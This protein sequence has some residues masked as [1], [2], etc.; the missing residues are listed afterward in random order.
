M[1]V[2]HAGEVDD[3]LVLWGELSE[4]GGTPGRRRGR[5]RTAKKKRSP[6]RDNTSGGKHPFSAGAQEIRRLL[7]SQGG[8][9]VGKDYMTTSI[10]LPSGGGRPVPSSGIGSKSTGSARGTTL[11][12]WSVEIL[13]LSRDEAMRVLSAVAR[14][15]TLLAGMVVGPDLAYWSDVLRLAS[16]MV[17]R[18]QILPGLLNEYVY[19][20]VW[21]PVL[22]GKDHERFT[23]LARHM[24][25][26][27]QAFAAGNE[28]RPKRSPAEIL[29]RVLG[30]LVDH[31]VRS[32]A[33][34]NL[35][36]GYGRR[37]HFDS[38]HDSWFHAL[39]GGSGML[40][41]TDGAAE[42]ETGINEWQQTITTLDDSPF[43]L[44]F[45]LEEPPGS[46]AK[47]RGRAWF[48]RYLLQSRNDPSLV[49]PADRVWG[50]KG[51]G[52][53]S[54]L[55]REGPRAKEFLLTSL[56]R[57][58]G[59]IAEMSPGFE[60]HGME[61]Y[62]VDV[63]GAYRFL[64]EEAP[65]LEQ[66]GYGIMLPAWWV[67]KGTKT[68]LAAQAVVTPKMRAKGVLNLDSVVRFDWRLALGD[69]RIT[70][71][72]L[73]SLAKIKSPLVSIRGQW[74]ET[75]SGEIRRAIRFL[76]KNRGATLRDTVMMEFGSNAAAPGWMDLRIVSRDKQ[77]TRMM[78]RL[79]RNAAMK[80]LPQPRGFTGTLRP[81][82][83]HGY[84][85]LSFLQ[86]LGIGGCLADDMGLGKTVQVLALV[87]RYVRAAGKGPIL[88]VCPTS[89]MDNWSR[90]AARFAPELSVTIHH[91]S[92]RSGGRTFAREAAG[93]DMVVSSYALLHRDI[94]FVRRVRWGG[95]I[96]DEAQNVKNAETKQS[97]AVRALDAGFRFALTG[98][99][100]ENSVADIW[101]I[102]EFLNP[103]LLGTQAEFKRNFF[104][105]I[106]TN[107]DG[108]AIDTLKRT[109]GP[110]ML[111]RLKT[112]R[113]V[114][115]DL[116]KK[117]EMN[118][119][120]SLTREQASL[121]A[122]VLKELDDRLH[123][124]DGIQRKG[125]IL[126][127]LSKLKQ[128]CNHPAHL[129][130]DG[131]AIPDRSG[132][133]A[134]LTEMLEEV[135]NSG[136]RALVFTQFVEMGEILVRHIHETFGREVAFLHGGVPKRQRDRMVERFQDGGF[137]VFVVSL[138]AGG[139]GLNLMAANHVF[140][141]DRWWNPAVENQ[142][143]DRAYRIGQ[144]RNVQVYKMV[145]TGTMEERIDEIIEG[146][147]EISENV[148]G[149]GEGWLT[150]L[151][152][153][154]IRQVLALSRE[155][156]TRI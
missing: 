145:C 32:A 129:L 29:R 135:I 4:S 105:P 139:T 67:G 108:G 2:L 91:G 27:G 155:E 126:A 55:R 114:I 30:R 75:G 122:S 54:A 79:R 69:K 152:N 36:P 76:A 53:P 84:S 22:V 95:V 12:Q 23:A 96:L 142:A 8:I 107:R 89:V 59:I 1:I 138:R 21:R 60:R 58:S 106:Q 117:M 43:R 71:K 82:Q 62:A 98:T 81:Y 44:C 101:S 123:S 3:S 41:D 141:F 113:T 134:R 78:N 140:H 42:L 136:E 47:A 70:L 149:T 11:V 83:L 73:Q 77:I 31:M 137:S 119:Y 110:F 68:R 16:S 116:P 57:A 18:Q 100:V 33:A 125:V 121:Y 90:E 130:K 144:K 94:G 147:R 10:W 74:I 5:R 124:T 88:L 97:H 46:G 104:V 109:I 40:E 92:G 63:D 156:A 51:G 154:D 6:G 127:T 72:E 66:L 93:H 26:A 61:G 34:E 143:T 111:R 45:R 87:Q 115:A 56:G 35:P 7:R 80:S 25:A 65:V 64:T 128:V 20:A 37:K 38:I 133:L 13:T 48:V 103:G 132:K 86:E 151:S 17:A 52:G 153:R 9:P 85:W 120:C 19:E 15:R 150:K 131:S 148:V 112:D 118:V 39:R 28:T 50:K 24:P 14:N 146:K 102:M 49:V 99:P